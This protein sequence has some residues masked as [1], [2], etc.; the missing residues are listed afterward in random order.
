VDE[1]FLGPAHVKLIWIA[2]LVPFNPLVSWLLRALQ[3]VNSFPSSAS[4]RARER[5]RERAHVRALYRDLWFFAAC[6]AEAARTFCFAFNGGG[7]VHEFE[8]ARME[9]AARHV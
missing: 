2:Y 7:F 4:A 8:Y 6:T 3:G 1:V 5:E 9:I